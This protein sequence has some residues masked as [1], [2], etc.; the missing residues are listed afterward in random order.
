MFK[1]LFYQPLYNGLVWITAFIPGHYLAVSIILFTLI[2]KL[3]LFP[4]SKRAVITQLKMKVIEP[5]LAQI[6]ES[7][8]DDRQKLAEK[9]M[10]VYRKHSLNPFSTLFL[11]LLQIPIFFALAQIFYK[12]AL[13]TIDTTLI[14]SFVALPAFVNQNLFF[15]D[16]STKSLLLGVTAGILQ[17][18]QIQYSLPPMKKQEP[19][20]NRTLKDDFARS[21]HIQ[22]KYVLPVIVFIASLGFT[23]S[24]ALYWIVSTVFTIG[25]EIYFRKTIKKE[26]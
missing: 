23:A 14:Y 13:A 25:Q 3:V 6:K 9:T 2:I 12:N 10:E 4:L 15:I 26:A 8:K 17:F 1:T 11:A 20:S 22:M 24:M 16:L 5:E 7:F 18:I 19:G 21:M